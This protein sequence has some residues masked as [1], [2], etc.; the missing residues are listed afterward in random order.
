MTKEDI[1][2]T[3]IHEVFLC[4]KEA[5]EAYQRQYDIMQKKI[6]AAKQGKPDFDLHMYDG[7][8]SQFQKVRINEES[9]LNPDSDEVTIQVAT[10]PGNRIGEEPN[11]SVSA[12]E[13]E[14]N[15]L[16]EIIDMERQELACQ[17]GEIKDL[18]AERTELYK[19]LEEK[20]ALITEL[21]TKLEEY[22]D[23]NQEHFRKEIADRDNII[24]EERAEMQ[25]MGERIRKLVDENLA[26]LGRYNELESANAGLKSQLANKD[27]IIAD[28]RAQLE[29]QQTTVPDGSPSG[30]G[31]EFPCFDFS[32]GDQVVVSGPFFGDGVPS[33][34]CTI[35]ETRSS[36]A[37]VLITD[38]QHEDEQYLVPYKFLTIKNLL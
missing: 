9:A 3:A 22:Q 5:G 31:E 12:L 23:C 32:E 38:G 27:A 21:R 1:I 36:G 37:L 29:Q 28:L 35:L 15:E 8:F 6:D 18:N 19:I 2:T 11:P 14:N 16:H 34:H 10:V 24:G 30:K 26:L 7:I 25:K 33:Q 13:K 20:D 4:G 17:Q